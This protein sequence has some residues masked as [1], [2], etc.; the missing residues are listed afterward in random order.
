MGEL[1]KNP[2]PTRCCDAVSNG[3]RTMS[4]HQCYRKI[5]VTRD[6][7]GYCKIHDPHAIRAKM[8]EKMADFTARNERERKAS[9]HRHA[10]ADLLRDFTAEEIRGG[11]VIVRRKEA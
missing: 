7:K 6:G 3:P 10:A 1:Y 11:Q 5:A 2:D 9:E 4:W 8:D